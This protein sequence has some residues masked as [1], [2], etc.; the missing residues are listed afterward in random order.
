MEKLDLKLLI[1]G[2]DQ[3]LLPANYQHDIKHFYG[4]K[5]I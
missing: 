4:Y 1:I 3:L 5:I 2:V